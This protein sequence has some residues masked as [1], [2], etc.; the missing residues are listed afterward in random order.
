[1]TSV[2]VVGAG[3][4]GLTSARILQEAGQSV[5]V[6]DKG[7]GVGGRMAT[8]RIDDAVFDHG[9]QF[10][11]A[12]SEWFVKL[13]STLHGAGI[14]DPWFAGDDAESHIRY[15]GAASMNAIAKHL[16]HGLDVRC[17][18][19]VT[20]IRRAADHWDVAFDS[21]DVLSCDACLITAP[22]PQA[23]TL[24]Y[25]EEL[26]L[27]A[28]TLSRLQNIS[29]DPCFAVLATLDG[30]SG[31]PTGGPFRPTDSPAI[32]LISDN[33]AKGVSPVPCIT[34]HSTVEFAR[35]YIEDPETAHT[36]MIEQVCNYLGSAITS[37]VIHR[38]RYAQPS[39]VFEAP[40]SVLNS[41]PLL[42]LAGDAF[43]GPRVEGAALSGKSAAEHILAG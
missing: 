27:D 3:M 25:S 16:A 17:S 22:I 33:Q 26:D 38:W 32:A 21:R 18:A 29:Y 19:T 42:I 12:R 28:Q 10:L 9:A 40:F 37:S 24:V 4:C 35:Q 6:V 8:R 1:M 20:S 14:V 34:I 30:A 43:G 31:L 36:I 11:T 5:V 39:A 41:R 7:R 23:L 15:R 13:V 2:I